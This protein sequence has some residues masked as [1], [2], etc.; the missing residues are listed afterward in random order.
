MREP[1][2]DIHHEALNELSAR[3]RDEIPA[4]V[5]ETERLLVAERPELREGL[6]PATVH[7]AAVHTHARFVALLDG[8]AGPDERARQVAFG[9]TVAAAGLDVETLLAGYR[10]GAQVSWR[11]VAHHVEALGLPAGAVLD[12]ATASM[13]YLDEL[14]ANSLEGFAREAASAE[15]ARSRARQALLEA[16]VA[17]RPADAEALAAPA[18]W[19]LP[20]RLRVAVVLGGGSGALDD[21]VLLR[22]HAA[23]AA[24]AIAREADDAALT[25]A[26]VTL[27]AGPLVAPSQTP[28]SL[29]GAQRLA[30][31]VAGGALPDDRALAWEDHLPALVV[32]A[33]PVAGAALAA[34]HLAPLAGLPPARARLLRE[35]LD[36][37]LQHPGRPR[38]IARVLQLHHQTVRYRLARLR[39]H[40]GDAALDDP[41]RRFELAL[42]LRVSAPPAARG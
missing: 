6:D 12:L 37:W 2:L 14:A 39:E 31:L 41:Q 35:T 33:D 23:G 17:G 4:M 40:F 42:A 22:G 8:D 27:A 15:G 5:D 29:A 16:L 26:G 36:A 24:L 28:A 34:R 7:A 21:R 32:G 19:P 38:E 11:R 25:H 3:L 13:A 9:A 18:G 10:V 20:E 1:H 30:Q